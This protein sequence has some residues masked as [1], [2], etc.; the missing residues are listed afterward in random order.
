MAN[1]GHF[2]FVQLGFE[3]FL[4][5]FFPNFMFFCLSTLNSFYFFSRSSGNLFPF[6]FTIASKVAGFFMAFYTHLIW[7]G[8]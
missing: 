3:L 6:N 7:V 8:F 5:Y 2:L 4:Q 1:A